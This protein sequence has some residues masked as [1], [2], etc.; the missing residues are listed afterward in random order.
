MPETDSDNISEN[1]VV[2]AD[3]YLGADDRLDNRRQ[4][5]KDRGA[6]FSTYDRDSIRL[7]LPCS[8]AGKLRRQVLMFGTENVNRNTPSVRV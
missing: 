7:L 5:L 3:Q 8:L 6:R 4:P 1:H 2:R